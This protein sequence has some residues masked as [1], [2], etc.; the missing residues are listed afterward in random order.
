MA[1]V[2]T[3]DGRYSSGTYLLLGTLAGLLAMLAHPANALEPAAQRGL[4]LV[5]T[6]CSGCHAIGKVGTSP[7]A[8]A[9]PFRTL[10]T[11][12]PVE[13]LAES[14]AEGIMTGHPAMHEWRLDPGQIGDLI[15]YLKTLQD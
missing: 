9:P 7:L 3:P 10:H 13:D 11:R 15:A 4:T 6:N 1:T 5:Q 12:Y 14:F 8:E 2:N